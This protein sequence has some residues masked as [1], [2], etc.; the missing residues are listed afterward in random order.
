MGRWIVIANGQIEDY[1][2]H[3]QQIQSEDIVICADGGVRHALHLGIIPLAIIGDMDS[4]DRET[5]AFFKQKGTKIYKFP[6]EKDEVDTLLALN[7]A[8]QHH[9]TEILLFGAIGE[10]MDHNLANCYLLWALSD[11]KISIKIVNEYQEIFIISPDKPG[12]VTGPV[13]TV[14]TLLPFT[15]EVKG[16]TI[17]GLQYPVPNGSFRHGDPLG[18]SNVLT[19]PTAHIS[20]T[21]GAIIAFRIHKEK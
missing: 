5:V 16:I 4:A 17:S 3:K 8:L 7:F 9:A 21:E 13:G 6:P 12:I 10:R 1:P 11:L 15:A 2:W 20:V 18:I 14:L 19:A